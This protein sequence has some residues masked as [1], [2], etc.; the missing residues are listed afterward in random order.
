MSQLL[1]PNA[2][3][4]FDNAAMR[5]H[6]ALPRHLALDEIAARAAR[7]ECPRHGMGLLA[8]ALDAQV[9]EPDEDPAHGLDKVR[10]RLAPSGPLWSFAR[11]LRAQAGPDDVVFFPSEAGGL[12]FAAACEDGAPRPRIAVFAHNLDRPRARF[13][14]KWW[15][16]R[17]RIDLFMA[18]SARQVAFLREFLAL[19]AQRVR[20]VW[21]HTDTEF[22]TPGPV[23][24]D[25]RRPLVVSVGL[26]Q[27]DYGTLAAA[28]AGLDVDVRISGFS[29]DAAVLAR[30]FPPELPANMSRRFYEWPELLQLYRDADV[31]VVSCRENRY[32][33]GV[34]SLMEAS[35]CATPV[36]ATATEGLSG[37]L[38][39]DSVVR[40]PPGDA[41]AMR[42]AI[43]ATLA[44][45][46]GAA[47]RAARGHDLALER[48]GMDRYLSEM[49]GAL[50]ALH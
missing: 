25:K 10:A 45:P 49:A 33:A 32:A 43:L 3:S 20:H 37:Y 29:S 48:Y 16:L 38:D 50:R 19:P 34:Q 23:S 27:R 17:D 28:T 2:G 1:R 26:E 39:D 11:R 36:I 30:T 6:I 42:R 47:Q 31:V 21:D 14:L 24:P 44:D 5:F 22:F 7:H 18:C 15:H 41:D 46:A 12:Q 4:G 8:Q 40:V 35:A 9:H 13:A